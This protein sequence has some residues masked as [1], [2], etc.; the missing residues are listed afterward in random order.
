M[1]R[2]SYESRPCCCQ[3]K[4]SAGCGRYRAADARTTPCPCGCYARRTAR[5]IAGIMGRHLPVTEPVETPHMALA[6][7][8]AR[9]FDGTSI[10]VLLSRGRRALRA[11]RPFRY[12]GGS[13]PARS[14]S[15]MES[16]RSSAPS[17]GGADGCPRYSRPRFCGVT[18]TV[19]CSVVSGTTGCVGGVT[20]GGSGFGPT[21]ARCSA[22]V[23]FGWAAPIRI[24]RAGW[25][26]FGFRVSTAQRRT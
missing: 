21:A 11:R 12:P 22:M 3:S 20:I 16:L 26:V 23:G 25:R 10:D 15:G 5:A 8:C 17:A 18:G 7:R 1:G 24:P 9:S 6:M 19:S 14:Q 4:S 2:P 13:A